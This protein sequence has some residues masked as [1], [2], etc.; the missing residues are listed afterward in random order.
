MP[1]KR[2]STVSPKLCSGS[3]QSRGDS[4]PTNSDS[5]IKP[6]SSPR[7]RR[8][9]APNEPHIADTLGWI[10]FKKGDYGN[11]LPA[12]QES[13]AKL[14][15]S[16]EIQFHVGM[17]H[18]MLGEEDRP[19]LR[20]RRP[21]MRVRIFPGKDDARKRLALLAIGIGAADPA[22]RTELQKYLRQQPNDPAALM[23]LADLQE[24][25]GAVDQAIKTYEKP[26][27]LSALRAGHPT[28]RPSLR[29]ACER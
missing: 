10:S 16:P 27:R 7:R 26:S 6:T 5:S 14:P 8:E 21:Q 24:R 22:A 20:C 2:C 23:R 19:V 28:A 1:T 13:A 15:D 9:A 25:D 17:A 18:Y 3:Q 12:L 29:P 4:I 11:A